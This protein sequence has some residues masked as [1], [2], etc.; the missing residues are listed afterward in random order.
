MVEF[1]RCEESSSATGQ[2]AGSVLLVVAIKAVGV[3]VVVAYV[4]GAR[5]AVAGWML[6]KA[7][8]HI[9]KNCFALWHSNLSAPPRVRTS[10]PYQPFVWTLTE[11]RSEL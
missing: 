2:T 9:P 3:V 7:D 1:G 6:H 5:M 4:K 10:I 11:F 8:S